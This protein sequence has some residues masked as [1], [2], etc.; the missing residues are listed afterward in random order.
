MGSEQSHNT[1]DNMSSL[2]NNL[3]DESNFMG[4]LP[5]MMEEPYLNPDPLDHIMKYISKKVKH[6]ET[7]IKLSILVMASTYTPN[8]LNLALESPQSEGKS[9]SLVEVSQ[10]FPPNDVWDLGG[11][12]PQVLTRERGYHV[13]RTT[14]KNIEKD[15][16]DIKEEL[17]VLT[18]SEEDKQKRKELRVKL[19]KI[20]DNAVKIVDMQG[21][22]LLFLE[23]PNNETFAKLRPILS[24]DKYEIEYKFVDRAYKNGP[25]ITM[26]ARIRGWPVAIYATA[27]NPQGTIWDQIRSRFIIVS[28]NMNKKKYK[29]ANKYTASKYGSISNP[30][31]LKKEDKEFQKCRNYINYVKSELYS[32]YY[33]TSHEEYFKPENISFTWNPMAKK[34]E[35]SFPSSIGQHIRDFKYF[36]ALMDISCLF[37]LFNRPYFEVGGYPHWMVTKW[38]LKNITEVF[39]NYHFFIKIGELP[40]KMFENII[41]EMDLNHETVDNEEGFTWKDLRD[42]MG[43]LDYPNSKTHLQNNIISPL[44]QIGLLSKGKSKSDQRI[45]I[46][47]PFAEKYEQLL[48]N[49]FLKINYGP[50]DLINDFTALEN[51]NNGIS[52][53]TLNSEV[54]QGRS[55]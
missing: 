55:P 19:I 41:Q 31:E 21:K 25:Q 26:E 3:S 52:T 23:A 16:S 5:Q 14:G 17:S 40:I 28:P 20:M 33:K 7:L 29:A 46:Y 30:I 53:L 36:M 27:D 8:P 12:T 4:S 38:D 6:E 9:Y 43:K 44:E 45:N 47:V 1:N 10:I 48:T 42:E 18:N 51:I 13:D 24:R 2:D 34:L 35:R 11:M 54:F 22:I 39:D 37:S 49:S 50:D 15:I 32:K